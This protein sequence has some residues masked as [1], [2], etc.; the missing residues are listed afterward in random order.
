MPGQG[1]LSEN[2]HEGEGTVMMPPRGWQ[3]SV[4]SAR[5]KID[6]AACVSRRHTFSEWEASVKNKFFTRKICAYAQTC[7]LSKNGGFICWK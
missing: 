2:L 6:G 7:G 5:N 3:D 1:S 4:I